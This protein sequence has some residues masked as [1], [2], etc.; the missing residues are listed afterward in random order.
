MLFSDWLC[1]FKSLISTRAAPS[2]VG[3]SKSQK[4]R[5]RRLSHG[6]TR[7]SIESLEQ[8]TMLTVEPITLTDPLYWGESASGVSEVSASAPT[9]SGLCSRVTHPISC[10]TI[11]T[12]R[13]TFSFR[14]VVP[15]RSAWSALIPL[16]A[17]V[18]TG[19]VSLPRSVPTDATS[20]FKVALMI[21]SRRHPFSA[22]SRS[23]STCA[24]WTQIERY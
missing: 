7:C 24:T 13:R 19:E 23:T 3:D 9:D 4:R 15:V 12:V 22:C 5:S 10:R 11:L 20:C 8:R 21:S 2:L 16:A 6:C 18:R 17:A 14:S 1:S